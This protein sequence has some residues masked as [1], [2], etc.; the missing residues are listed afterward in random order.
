MHVCICRS[1]SL[2]VSFFLTKSAMLDQLSTFSALASFF[3]NLKV[4]RIPRYTDYTHV[5][6]FCKKFGLHVPYHL[7]KLVL[8]ICSTWFT[9]KPLCLSVK[10]AVASNLLDFFSLFTIFVSI[11]MLLL[12]LVLY[13]LHWKL[14]TLWSYPG[15][16]LRGHKVTNFRNILH[17]LPP[18]DRK[19]R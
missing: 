1:R 3:F 17:F 16:N 10:Y 18:P 6:I 19:I 13:I 9:Y 14:A 7:W 4:I 2:R 11:T 8:N 5:D 15:G 12:P